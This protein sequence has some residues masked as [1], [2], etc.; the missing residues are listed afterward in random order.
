MLKGLILLL[1]ITVYLPITAQ[2]KPQPSSQIHVIENDYDSQDKVRIAKRADQALSEIMKLAVW[3][4]KADH[5]DSE[6]STVSQGWAKYQGYLPALVAALKA[7]PEAIGDYNPMS[8]W[9][10]DTYALLEEAL[11]KEMCEF[12]HLDDINT[13]NYTIPV[14]FALK[15]VL[16]PVDIDIKEYELHFDPFSG[17]ITY[18]TVWISCTVGTYGTAMFIICTPLGNLTEKFAIQV[19]GPYFAPK[20]YPIFW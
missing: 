7:N 6:A 10:S 16:G 3:K 18:W 14:V 4:L 1:T 12:L 13:L 9:L 15:D 2:A 20:V 17:V 19:M 8:K 11:G 5:L